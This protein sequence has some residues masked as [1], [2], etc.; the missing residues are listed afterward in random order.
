MLARGIPTL[1]VLRF[2][3]VWEAAVKLTKS[4]LVRSVGSQT[5]NLEE[6]STILCCVEAAMNSIPLTVRSERFRLLNSRPLF[7][8]TFLSVSSGSWRSSRPHRSTQPLETPPTG[9]QD[10]KKTTERT[11]FLVSGQWRRERAGAGDGPRIG[12]RLPGWWKQ[13]CQ[14]RSLSAPNHWTSLTLVKCRG[15]FDRNYF[16]REQAVTGKNALI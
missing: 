8:W 5:W 9:G 7:Y 16:G 11:C 12:S 4:Q 15:G 2:G 13:C 1:L 6:F 14:R 10:E 3:G